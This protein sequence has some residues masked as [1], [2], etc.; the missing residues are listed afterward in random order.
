MQGS[1]LHSA[2]LLEA[3]EF[4]YE[5][6]QNIGF[7]V[8]KVRESMADYRDKQGLFSKKFIWKR[9]GEKD[10]VIRLLLW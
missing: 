4:I 5:C 1:T 3:M 6:A 9:V 10:K 7:D 2:Q 8:V